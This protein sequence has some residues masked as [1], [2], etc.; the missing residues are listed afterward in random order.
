[1]QI[2]VKAA[3]KYSI[4]FVDTVLIMQAD[5]TI[6]IIACAVATVV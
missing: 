5:T 6:S 2:T 3:D 1:M 4:I